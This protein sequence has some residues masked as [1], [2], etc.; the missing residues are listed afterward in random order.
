MKSATRSSI[1]ATPGQLMGALKQRYVAGAQRIGGVLSTMRILPEEVPP[2]SQR[3]R[4]WAVSLTRVHDSL[5]IAEMSVPWWT[6]EAIDTVDG[7]FQARA[8][9][10]RAFE[11]G[12][13][14]S[15]LW[16]ADRVDEVISIEHH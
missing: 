7:W 11:Y 6:Y 9:P 1:R 14:A 10:I 8:R 15:T 12:S 4:H 3:W 16:L 13:G 2:I 5:G